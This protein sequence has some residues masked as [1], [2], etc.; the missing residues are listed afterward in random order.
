MSGTTVSIVIA[1]YNLGRYLGE[2][3][4][5]VLAQ[6][7]PDREVIVIDDGST[8]DTAARIAPFRDRI[9]YV[10]QPHAGLA[11]ARNHGLRLARGDYV[12]VIDAD[13]LWAPEKLATQVAIAR[14]L[15][16]CGMVLCDGV[17]FEGDAVT[18]PH[19]LPRDLRAM[20]EAAGQ[21]AVAMDVH[22]AM[23]EASLVSCPAQT[24]VPREVVERTGWFSGLSAQDY[25]YW[26][27]IA[28]RYPV[29]VHGD[30]LAR[31]R[32]RD[33]SMSGPRNRRMVTG[34]LH[35]LPVLGAHA[36][37]CEREEDKRAIFAQIRARIELLLRPGR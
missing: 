37:R 8:D 9:A 27:R 14:R 31:W 15:P 16:H 11:A 1:T 34:V 6:T 17:E 2:T 25:D 3:L 29:A 32:Y 21:P 7:H 30:V 18:V 20:L 12:A 19:L 13:D 35:S 24:L 33:D 22:G 5:S 4:S 23:I 36:E 10:V 26:L 28:Q